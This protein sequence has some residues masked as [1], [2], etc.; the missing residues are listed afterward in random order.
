MF[1]SPKAAK[2]STTINDPTFKYTSLN[3]FKLYSVNNFNVKNRINNCTHCIWTKQFVFRI[4][5]SP[6]RM[7]SFTEN[8]TVYDRIQLFEASLVCS[9]DEI[10]LLHSSV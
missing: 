6:R 3:R 7:K 2:F 10:L 4:L 9:T 5:V 8:V 1:K